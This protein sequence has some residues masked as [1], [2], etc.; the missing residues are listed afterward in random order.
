MRS[1]WPRRSSYLE[2]EDDN[3]NSAA[4]VR[5]I[6]YSNI[7]SDTYFGPEWCRPQLV[8]RAICI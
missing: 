8:G 6:R 4:D 7:Y 1:N 2:I 5:F 3:E